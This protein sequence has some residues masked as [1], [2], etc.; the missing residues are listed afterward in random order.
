MLQDNKTLKNVS[1]LESIYKYES[2]EIISHCVDGISHD[3]MYC[4]T[5]IDNR[6]LIFKK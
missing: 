2:N 4:I 3:C 6:V 1:R 5:G